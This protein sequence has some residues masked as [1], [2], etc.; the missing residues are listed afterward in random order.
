MNILWHKDRFWWSAGSRFSNS[1]CYWNMTAPVRQWLEKTKQ[2]FLFMRFSISDPDRVQTQV[3]TS[4]VFLRTDWTA[5]N[6][7]IPLCDINLTFKTCAAY[8]PR[9]K[10]KSAG[11]VVV[12][13]IVV[14]W[15]LPTATQY[16]LTRRIFNFIMSIFVCCGDLCGLVR[17][18]IKYT[19][20]LLGLLNKIT[21]WDL[22]LIS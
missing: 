12:N 18:N 14:D 13:Q 15:C 4:A 16:F 11:L 6:P 5:M 8:P 17:I 20:F 7:Q 9:N 21:T 22:L 1:T 2:M 10:E 19:L 3:Q